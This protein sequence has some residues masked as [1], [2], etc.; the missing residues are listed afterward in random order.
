MGRGA[1]RVRASTGHS[2]PSQLEPGSCHG[3]RN[4]PHT[5]MARILTTHAGSL[6]RPKHLVELFARQSRGETVDGKALAQAIESSTRHVIARQLDA[7]VD[8][9]NNGEQP[10]E[11]FFTPVR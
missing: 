11:S 4:A 6:P 3:P 9:G 7:G 10:R 5:R 2:S 1:R 8:V